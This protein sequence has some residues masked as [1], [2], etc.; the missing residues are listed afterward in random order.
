MAPRPRERKMDGECT[1][2][3]HQTR[4]IVTMCDGVNNNVG[5]LVIRLSLLTLG[6]PWGH[7]VGL[8]GACWGDIEASLGPC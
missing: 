6:S 2:H 7:R 8:L 4:G 3:Y 5:R 1:A